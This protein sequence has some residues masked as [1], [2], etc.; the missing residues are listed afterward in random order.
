MQPEWGTTGSESEGQS[1]KE[2]KDVSVQR[3]KRSPGYKVDV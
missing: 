3:T 2:V 1:L